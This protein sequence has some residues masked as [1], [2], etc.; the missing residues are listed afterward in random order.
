MLFIIGFLF[1]KEPQRIKFLYIRDNMFSIFKA[2]LY[3][4]S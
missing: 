1:I 2:Y 4:N 3:F